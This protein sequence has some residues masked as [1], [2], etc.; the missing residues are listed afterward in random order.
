MKI[1]L[2]IKRIALILI[3]VSAIQLNSNAQVTLV[4]DSVTMGPGYA[5]EVYYSMENGIVS[6]YP[7]D[8]WDIAFRTMIMSSSIITNDGMNVMLYT[9]PKADTSGW[10]TVDT[11][12]WETWMP[13]YNGVDDWENGAFGIN[14]TGGLDF[15]W[16]VYNVSNHVITGD[17]LYVIRLRD[18][19]FRKLWIEA[20][21][22]VENL[23]DFRYANIDG[24]GE[25]MVSL[26]CSD[27]ITK[28]FVGYSLEDG[29]I[30]DFQPERSSW[31][32]VFTKY[33]APEPPDTVYNFM[34]IE[35]NADVFTE[36]FYHVGPDFTG[37]N[38]T[39]WDSTKIGIG[40][41]WK[42]F[43]GTGWLLTDSLAY[44]VKNKTGD[45][46]KMVITAYEGSSTGKIVFKR[47]RVARVG[48]EHQMPG[49]GL[50]IYPNPATDRIHVG[51]PDD[52]G[53]ITLELMDLSGRTLFTEKLASTGKPFVMN[54]S[55][56]RAGIYLVK[57]TAGSHTTT[58][59][60]IVTK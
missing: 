32:L 23:Y 5:N 43:T 2:Q 47:A 27:Y 35:S 19:S 52:P 26:N 34:G 30:V 13:M 16:G 50:R 54:T 14:A 15:G 57:V 60:F 25:Q 21:K 51:L 59:K 6:T 38:T 24:T 46:F 53:E 44:F 36:E 18:G 56:L 55:T 48:I 58:N 4:A 33:I 39:D 17:S 20:K 11:S 1:L 3:T 49:N 9:Y 37:W 41:D 31:D 28:E 45:I 42:T 22:A 7:R 12:G 40:H 10:A 29:T 8:N